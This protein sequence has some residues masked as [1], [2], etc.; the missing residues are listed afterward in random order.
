MSNYNIQKP[1]LKWVGGKTQIMSNI[2][3]NI[4]KEINNYYEPFLGGGSVLLMILS[5]Q[6]EN[7]IKINGKI[8]VSDLNKR[9]INI[10]K[11]IKSNKDELFEYIEKYINTYDKLTGDIINRKPKNE[12]EA[13]TSKESYYYWIR[14]CYNELNKK[15]NLTIN[16]EINLSSMFMFMNKTCFRGMYREGPNGYNVPYGHYKKTP[17]IITKDELYK[18]SDLIQNVEFMNYSF[19]DTFTNMINDNNKN[20]FIYCDPPYVPINKKSFVGYNVDGFDNNKHEL[21]FNLLKDIEKNKMK[22]MLS[23]SKV[24]YV[25]KSFKNYNI[26]NVEVKRSI[27][28]KNPGSKV[29]EVIITNY[30]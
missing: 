25:D 11:H 17:T 26:K 28:S 12:N 2:I 30:K 21:L 10:Y 23:N 15:Q 9:L 20:N 27:N 19:E 13:K 29:L 5:L 16:D 3:D 8:Y 6:K 1:F 18:I 4:P 24:D 22:F 14:K 7:K